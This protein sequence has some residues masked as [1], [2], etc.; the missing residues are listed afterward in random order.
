M[1]KFFNIS[2]FFVQ[3]MLKSVKIENR[4]FFCYI[5]AFGFSSIVATKGLKTLN[6]MFNLNLKFEKDEEI[7]LSI[8]RLD[9]YIL[10]IVQKVNNDG[11]ESVRTGNRPDYVKFFPL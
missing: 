10:L 2:I 1:L 6:Y 9:D 4:N 8:D 7:N 3:T 5:F 11:A